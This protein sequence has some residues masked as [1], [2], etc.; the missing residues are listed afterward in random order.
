MIQNALTDVVAT[1][2]VPVVAAGASG[3]TALFEEAMSVLSGISVLQAVLAEFVLVSLVGL[4]VLALRSGWG[5]QA[6]RYS[7]G[8][9]VFSLLVGIPTTIAMFGLLFVGVVLMATVFGSVLGIPIIGAVGSLLLVWHAI[10]FVALG[11]W[12]AGRLDIEHDAGGVGLGACIA[13]GIVGIAVVTPT[14]GVLP[15]LV[16]GSLGVGAGLRASYGRYAVDA[17][18]R[19]IPTKHQHIE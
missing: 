10:G 6:L 2:A 4:S 7:R 12:S 5:G 19:R 11:T 18:Q 1:T 3:T 17:S 8:G 15:L 9:L 14:I 13:A 16:V